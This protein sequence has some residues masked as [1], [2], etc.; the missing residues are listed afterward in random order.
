MSFAT[1]VKKEIANV[2]VDEEGLKA[3]LYGFLKL[4][5]ELIISNKK[6]ICQFKTNSL[7]IVRRITSTIKKLYQISVDVLEK[8][9]KNLDHNNIYYVSIEEKVKE[10]LIDLQIMND[11]MDY[12]DDIN[13]R[14]SVPSVL[15]GMFLAKGSINDPKSSRYHFE[16]SCNNIEEANYVSDSLLEYGVIAKVA[17][18]K[19]YYVAYVKKA[20][21]IGD[22]LKIMGAITNLFDFENERI[23][24]DLNNVVNR[25]INCDMANCDKMQKAA[26]RQLKAIQIIEDKKGFE[27]LSIRLMEAVTLRINNPEG[28]LQDLSNESE[29]VVGRYISKSGLNHCFKDL[30]SYAKALENI[31]NKK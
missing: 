28:S 8:E 3:E 25:M 2:E 23:K 7:A 17:Q 26:N 5:G 22:V 31:E 9:R 14:Y 24:R 1:D 6:L 18:R 19:E 21:S 12:I 10:I 15:R 29:D 13:I 30:E 27:S 4:K 20:E 11:D 16:I